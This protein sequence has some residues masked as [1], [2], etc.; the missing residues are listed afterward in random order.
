MREIWIRRKQNVDTCY[1]Y[2]ESVS[3][4][5]VLESSANKSVI[6]R[7]RRAKRRPTRT[8]RARR[9]F[10]LREFFTGLLVCLPFFPYRRIGLHFS[11]VSLSPPETRACGAERG[12]SQAAA[13]SN[14]KRPAEGNCFLTASTRTEHVPLIDP[15]ICVQDSS[16]LKKCG[17]ATPLAVEIKREI[18]NAASFFSSF[19]PLDFEDSASGEEIHI[20]TKHICSILGGNSYLRRRA[21]SDTATRRRRSVC[22]IYL[23]RRDARASRCSLFA[24]VNYS[25]ELIDIS[26]GCSA[27][28][29]RHR[30]SAFGARF[31]RKSSRVALR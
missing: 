24:R 25:K 11:C 26:A 19:Q 4:L 18:A 7:F 12:R 6:G 13:A 23:H 1:D 15:I 14:G 21:H 20:Y 22:D 17:A 8:E 2:D 16:W 29:R 30:A 31:S 27:A 9:A 3:P 10:F 5:A 28:L